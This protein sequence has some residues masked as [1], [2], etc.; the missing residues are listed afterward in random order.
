MSFRL[1]VA[2]IYFMSYSM[3]A[4]LNLEWHWPYQQILQCPYLSEASKH[5]FF[6]HTYLLWAFLAYTHCFHSCFI[7]KQQVSGKGVFSFEDILKPNLLLFLCTVSAYR[8]GDQ[9]ACSQGQERVWFRMTSACGY[10]NWCLFHT[11][12]TGFW[13]GKNTDVSSLHFFFSLS[14]GLIVLRQNSP[15]PSSP[16]LFLSRRI[17]V[18]F[19]D[20]R[21]LHILHILHMVQP[22]GEGLFLML[23]IGS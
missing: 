5:W 2:S 17:I 22:E 4:Y 6:N 1:A 3:C 9:Y 7:F 21:Y 14:W 13:F 23:R 8:N 19:A 11:I 10:S 20:I 15:P 18:T 12:E 16:E